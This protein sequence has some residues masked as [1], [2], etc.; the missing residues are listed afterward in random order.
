M[1]IVTVRNLV[2]EY[3]TFRLNSVNF[4][5]DAGK[6][7]GFIS[8]N[9]AGKTTTIKSMLNLVHPD[10]GEIIFF[11]K[12]L[13]EHEAEIKKQIGYSTGIVNWYPRKKIRD[14]VEVTKG[15]YDTWDQTAYHKFLKMFRLDENKT[16][17]ELSEGMKVK[18]NLLLALSHKAEILILDEPTSGLDPFSRDELLELFGELKKTGVAIFFSTHIISDIEK[19]ADDIVY[20]S[21]GNIVAAMSK[22]DFVRQFSMPGESLEQ[23]FLRLERGELK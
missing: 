20:I 22:P 9:G 7:T 18:C 15:F 11:N 2:K 4:S 5:L 13:K 12:P 6:I 23:T 8:R 3:P 19:C 17:R 10:S 16:P 1:S 14:I 21:G